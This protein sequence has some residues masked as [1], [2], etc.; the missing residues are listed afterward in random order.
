MWKLLTEI[1]WLTGK[2]ERQLAAAN[3]TAARI[4][5]LQQQQLALEEE[6]EWERARR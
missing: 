5:G 2:H 6:D 3:T 1:E 4:T